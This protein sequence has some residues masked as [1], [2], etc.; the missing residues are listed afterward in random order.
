MKPATF[1]SLITSAAMALICTSCNKS[2][3][4]S[5]QSSAAAPSGEAA[6]VS[7][8]RK[9][10]ESSDTKTLDS[11]LLSDGSPAEVVEFFKMMR[12]V[13]AGATVV[14][15]KL[16]APTAEDTAK[17]GQTMPMPDGRSCKLPIAPT[18]KLVVTMKTEG[19]ND[20]STSTST[21]PVAEKDGKLIIPLPVPAA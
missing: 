15:V 12:E 3:T 10:L 4:D 6:F 9:A 17:F 13:P 16:V 14:D 7:A 1:A 18:K 8:Y 2:A 5:K 21:L 11:F 20:N 19:P